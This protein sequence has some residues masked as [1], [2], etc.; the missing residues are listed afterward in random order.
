MAT[1]L[2]KPVRREVTIRGMPFVVTIAQDGLKLVGKGRRKGLEM[3][4]E[5]LT[6]GEAALA[7]ALTASLHSGVKLEPSERT[8]DG[9]QGNAVARPPAKEPPH[10][11]RRAAHRKSR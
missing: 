9:D 6:S 1:K 11:K 10:G 7:L 5:A 2:E 4:W 3:S 8:K